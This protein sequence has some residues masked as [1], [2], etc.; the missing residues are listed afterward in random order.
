MSE[1]IMKEDTMTQEEQRV[2]DMNLLTARIR[3]MSGHRRPITEESLAK[4]CE[5]EQD[6]AN[7]LLEE[8]EAANEDICAY[9]GQKHKYFYVYPT[10]AHNYVRSIALSE[11]KDIKNTILTLVR[12]DSKTYP[13]PTK[14]ADFA[15]EPYRYTQIQVQNAVRELQRDPDNAD[16]K[17]YNSKKGTYFLYSTLHL[18]EKLAI[19][20]AEDSEDAALWF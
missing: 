2:A 10:L 14:A 18:P 6:Y 7:A 9:A 12:Y 5:I 15:K 4:D 19:K 17:V 3:E 13:R 8:I 1:E 11:E 20:L 16:L